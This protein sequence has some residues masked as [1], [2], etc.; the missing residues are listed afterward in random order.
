MLAKIYRPSKT[1]T[2]SGVAASRRWILEY[3]PTEGLSIDPLMGWTSSS[4]TSRQV[5]MFFDTRDQAIA[6]ARAH[7]IPHQVAEPNERPRVLKSYSENF[8]AYRKEPWS[9]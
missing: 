3:E 7:N 2:Q 9:H 4:N 1:A 6:F 5:R 8:S